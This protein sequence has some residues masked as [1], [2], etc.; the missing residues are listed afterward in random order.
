MLTNLQ[1]IRCMAKPKVSIIIPV[2]GVEKYINKCITSILNQ[3]MEDFEAII[4]DDGSLDKSIAIAR[5][6][7]GDD[8]R[9]MF[10]HKTNGGQGSA[11][12]MGLDIAKGDYIVFIDSD[13]YFDSDFIKLMYEA[14]TTSKSEVGI[15]DVRFVSE[16]YKELFVHIN[17]PDKYHMHKDYLN[18]YKHVSNFF[19]D[20]IFENSVFDGMR[21][22]ESIRTFEDAHFTFKLIYNKKIVKVDKPLYNYLQRVGSTSNSLPPSYIEDRIAIKDTQLEF[23]KKI[24]LVDKDY[25]NFVYL[26]TFVFFTANKLAK[27]ST[28]YDV[29]IQKLFGALDPKIFV[30]KNILQV[31]KRHP[32]VG[33]ALLVLKISPKCFRIAIKTLTLFR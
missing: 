2:Y 12:N 15:C 24:N 5:Q 17:H 10:L 11:R 18:G 28:E 16:S 22:D 8:P 32:S 20:K 3:T 4:I 6:L 1:S 25:L 33:F 13:D 31:I 29:D 26:R 21:F 23:A 19:C 14:I 9:F 27:Y 7:V 30:I